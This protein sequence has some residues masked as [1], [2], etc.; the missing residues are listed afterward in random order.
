MLVASLRE[1]Q[2]QCAAIEKATEERLLRER[3]ND[4]E[5]AMQMFQKEL[6]EATTD[7][8]RAPATSP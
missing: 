3:D 4:V 1:S 8:K 7:P 6:A 5:A 2:Q